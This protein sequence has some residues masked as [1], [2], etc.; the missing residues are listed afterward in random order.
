MRD[1]IGPE[2]LPGGLP[3]APQCPFCE[4][5]GTELMNAFGSQLS[6]STYW[7]K[8][9]RSPF[10]LMKWRGGSGT[11]PSGLNV[12]ADASTE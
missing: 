8:E 11:F 7:C 5:S 12:E 10:E 9:C 2:R 6:V 3:K 1:S 4:G